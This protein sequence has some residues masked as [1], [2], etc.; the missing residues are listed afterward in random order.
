MKLRMQWSM[1]VRSFQQV[2]ASRSRPR[3]THGMFYQVRGWELSSGPNTLITAE[4]AALS[5]GYSKG[6]TIGNNEPCT[7]NISITLHTDDAP[8][9]TTWELIDQVSDDIVCVGAGNYSAGA[10]VTENCCLPA[11]CYRLRVLDAG[12]DGIT[13]GGYVVREQLTNARIVDNGSNFSTGSISA[14]SGGGGSAY[15]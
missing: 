13:G 3:M 4:G 6:L 2:V 1:K 11:G 10:S 12:G 15:R 8:A 14:I 7:E 9:E 5:T